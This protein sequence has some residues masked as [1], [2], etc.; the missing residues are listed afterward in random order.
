EGK[1]LPARFMCGDPVYLKGLYDG[2]IDSDG[3]FASD[4]R[5]CFKNT[6][7]RLIELFGLLCF[8]W[9]GSFPNVHRAAPSAG[10]LSGTTDERCRESYV[11]RLNVT[12]FKRHL[13]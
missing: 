2:L 9:T 10:G 6:S 1:H 12:H 8:A 13:E 11:A 5:V 3:F 4:G 7:R